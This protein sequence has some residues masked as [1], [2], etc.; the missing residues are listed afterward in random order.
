MEEPG[1]VAEDVGGDLDLVTGDGFHRIATAVHLGE[2][3]LD[4]HVAPLEI[5]LQKR[6][7]LLV[8]LAC[9]R[10]HPPPPS[11]RSRTTLRG[12]KVPYPT[13]RSPHN[14]PSPDVDPERLVVLA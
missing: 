11:R 7:S 2:D 5:V 8:H 1:P 3:V 12:S 10:R 9:P 14:G 4:D 6:H 13:Y